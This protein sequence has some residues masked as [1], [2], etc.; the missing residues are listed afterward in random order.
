MADIEE[1]SYT[2][3]P[4]QL[5]CSTCSAEFLFGEEEQRLFSRRNFEQPKRCHNCR[6]LKKLNT[7]SLSGAGSESEGNDSGND[8]S[9]KAELERQHYQIK[10]LSAQLNGKGS[11]NYSSE[12]T[13]CRRY[14]R[15]G[16][17]RFGSECKYV[18]VQTPLLQP[19]N[20]THLCYP[21]TQS[22]IKTEDASNSDCHDIDLGVSSSRTPKYGRKQGRKKRLGNL[23]GRA[24]NGSGVETARVFPS[25]YCNGYSADWNDESKGTPYP[26]F[27][28]SVPYYPVVDSSSGIPTPYPAGHFG[29]VD[30][31]QPFVNFGYGALSFNPGCGYNPYTVPGHGGY[32]Q[33]HRVHKHTSTYPSSGLQQ[34]T[35]DSA[36]MKHVLTE[37]KASDCDT[38]DTL[39]FAAQAKVRPFV[40]SIGTSSEHTEGSDNV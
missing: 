14:L 38:N 28:Y 33:T 20:E 21:N 10:L 13:I 26:I 16:H 3:T 17:C 34:V 35:N 6:L 37:K 32:D 15:N 30:Y 24:P 18:H 4:M 29:A 5:S 19:T 22:S 39:D 7:F 1:P 9:L 27:Q 36:Q 2:F 12:P 31:C 40:D 23:V 11:N 25:Y 8:I